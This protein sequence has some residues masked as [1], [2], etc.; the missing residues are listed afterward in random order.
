MD[1]TTLGPLEFIKKKLPG[2]LPA[3]GRVVC[4]MLVPIPFGMEHPLHPAAPSQDKTLLLH[5][6]AG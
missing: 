2:F 3:C 6:F 1:S 4:L 5:G